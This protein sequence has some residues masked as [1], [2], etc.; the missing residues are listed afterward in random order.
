M[1]KEKQKARSIA[2]ALRD[3]ET[4]FE[5]TIDSYLSYGGIRIGDNIANYLNVVEKEPQGKYLDWNSYLAKD[6]DGA[7]MWCSDSGI[8]YAIRLDRH[9]YYKGHDLIGFPILVF[10]M[11][12]EKEPRKVEILWTPTKDADHGQNQHVYDID[13]NRSGSKGLQVWTWRK[14]IVSLLVYDN[15]WHD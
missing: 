2:A 14:R 6:I 10:L 9:C 7:N 12:L 8:I 15:T 3:N 13:I 5:L 11:I 4:L 1:Q